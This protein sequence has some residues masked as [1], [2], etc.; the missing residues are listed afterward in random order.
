LDNPVVDKAALDRD[1]THRLG[2]MAIF[3]LWVCPSFS[4]TK[5]EL[6]SVKR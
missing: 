3:G 4:Y 1:T 2:A 5:T 6:S